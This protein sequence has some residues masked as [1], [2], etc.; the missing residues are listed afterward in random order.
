MYLV[1]NAREEMRDF[2]KVE[3]VVSKNNNCL[4]KENI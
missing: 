1:R 4:I 2:K 3:I